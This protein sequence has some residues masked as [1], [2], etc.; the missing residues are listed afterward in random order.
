ME[1]QRVIHTIDPV[2]DGRSHVLVLGTMPS[3]ASRQVGFYYGH[4]QN[5]FWRVMERL[6]GRADHTLQDN[7]DRIAFLLSERIALWDV[8][9][10][11]SIEGA[12]DAS[13]ADPAP[14]DL[15]RILDA[16]PIKRVFT[17]G[18]TAAK[19]CR[20]FDGALLRERGIEHIALPSTSAANA[21]MRLDDLVAAYRPL[22][23]AL[24]E[25]G[26]R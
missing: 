17:T 12:S 23:D 24:H 13:I 14:N 10:S 2:F 4:P 19:L 6:F 22:Y 11:C 3:P 18:G 8:L 15:T 26:G 20:R 9:A 7:D 21:R 16:A 1:A 5:R 25:D